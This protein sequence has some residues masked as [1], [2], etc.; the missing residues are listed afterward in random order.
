MYVEGKISTEVALWK[1]CV[2]SVY[3]SAALFHFESKNDLE[4][5]LQEAAFGG[6]N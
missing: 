4:P 6:R 1:Y 3:S 5:E 2:N